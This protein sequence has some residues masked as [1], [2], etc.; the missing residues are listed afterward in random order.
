LVMMI[1]KSEKVDFSTIGILE[2]ESPL[3]NI[4]FR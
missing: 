3:E 1:I 2:N 4:V